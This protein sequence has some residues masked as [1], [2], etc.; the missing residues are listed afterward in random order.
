MR[1]AAMVVP[2]LMV[3][4]GGGAVL[5]TE[6]GNSHTVARIGTG[7][8]IIAAKGANC[9]NCLCPCSDPVVCSPGPGVGMHRGPTLEW[10]RR[11]LVVGVS[12]VAV[13]AGQ[14][15]LCHVPYA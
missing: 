15:I 9:T 13:C 10:A 3:V 4:I 7:C 11:C 12:L 6:R 2:I 1:V 14:P 8:S 5:P